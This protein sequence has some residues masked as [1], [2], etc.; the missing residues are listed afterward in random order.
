MARGAVDHSDLILQREE[1][2]RE[3]EC[4]E[5]EIRSLLDVAGWTM[6]ADP[7]LRCDWKKHLGL[8]RGRGEKGFRAGCF[9]GEK[10]QSRAGWVWSQMACTNLEE[11]DGT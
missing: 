6:T 4:C 1:R 3:E 10:L 5:Q 8:R 7:D 9:R 2:S 11:R